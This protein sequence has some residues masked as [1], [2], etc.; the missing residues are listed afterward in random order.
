MTSG[1]VPLDGRLKAIKIVFSVL[2]AVT[3]LAAFSDALE[4]SLLG[5][6]IAGEDVSDAQ[7]DNNDLR[8]GLIALVQFVLFIAALVV[9]IRWMRQA[10]RNVDV[11]AGHAAMATVGRSVRGSCR[12]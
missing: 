3:L 4:I 1:Y 12:S 5:R 7:L 2:A 6:L 11:A 8:Q 10:Y 9:F